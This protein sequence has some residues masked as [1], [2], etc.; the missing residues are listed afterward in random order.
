MG[1]SI[2]RLGVEIMILKGGA[3]SLDLES[4]G[5]PRSLDLEESGGRARMGVLIL[6]NIFPL[7]RSLIGYLQQRK[8]DP[9][10]S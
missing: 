4:N 10:Q 1:T 8:H 7:R 3:R 6:V 5:C 2:G 9:K